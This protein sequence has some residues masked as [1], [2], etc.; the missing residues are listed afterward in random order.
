MRTFRMVAAGFACAATVVMAGPTSSASA[1]SKWIDG[2]PVSGVIASTTNSYLGAGKTRPRCTF[3]S[4]AW[5]ETVGDHVFVQ[6]MCA[7]G[8]SVVGHVSWKN[9]KGE[10]FHRYCHNKRGKGTQARCNLDWP[11]RGT[12][13]TLVAGTHG[14]ADKIEWGV[15]RHFND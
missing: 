4:L 13:K 11:E 6:D 9:A 10:V 15:Y 12:P 8:R 2:T 14:P 1:D 5:V 3:R 7:D